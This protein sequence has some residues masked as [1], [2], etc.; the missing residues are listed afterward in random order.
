[1]KGTGGV[2]GL[3]HNPEACYCWMLAGPEQAQ[4]LK[5]FEDV[6]NIS[7][8][9]NEYQHHDEGA[10]SQKTFLKQANKIMLIIAD[11]YG[12]PFEDTCP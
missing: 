11:E 5:E 1:M 8:D 10:A 9:R 2:K 6:N 3:T 12:N 4:L 7:N